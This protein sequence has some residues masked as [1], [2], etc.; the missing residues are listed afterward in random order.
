MAT[1]QRNNSQLG[2]LDT[3]LLLVVFIAA[4]KEECVLLPAVAMHITV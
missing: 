4:S 2:I 3:T 1:E